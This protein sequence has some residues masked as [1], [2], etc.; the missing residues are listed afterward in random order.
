MLLALMIALQIPAVQTAAVSRVLRGLTGDLNCEIKVGEFALH[1]FNTLIVKDVLILDKNAYSSPSHSPQDTIIKGGTIIARF[2]LKGLL[3]DDG[4]QLSRAEV[5]DALICLV[6]E[7]NEYKS[8]FARAFSSGKKKEGGKNPPTVLVKRARLENVEF[9]MANA[10]KENG[11]DSH[12]GVDWN[13]LDLIL[14]AEAKAIKYSDGTFS[15]KFN[16]IDFSEHCGLE[17]D[18]LSGNLE[19]SETLLSLEEL[20]LKDKY[21]SLKLKELSFSMDDKSGWSN[22]LSEV[23]MTALFEPSTLS[24][25]TLA[26]F[27]PALEGN[28]SEFEI[29]SGKLNG[30]VA[31]L[32]LK[33]LALKETYSGVSCAA[34][35]AVSGLPDLPRLV[36]DC[37]IKELVFNGLGADRLISSFIK[38]KAPDIESIAG[39]EAFHFNAKVR[40]PISHFDVDGRLKSTAGN[41]STGICI[42]NLFTNKDLD[43]HG[44]ASCENLDIG[45][46][47]GKDFV[48]ELSMSTGLNAVAGKEG[49]RLS[50]DSLVVDRLKLL[51]YDYS[52]IRATGIYSGNEFD[53]RVVCNDP[54]LNFMFQ[55][56]ATLSTKTDNAD[57]RF[58]ASLGYADLNAL[59]IDKRGKS[60]ISVGNLI[61]NYT[62]IKR[63][64]LRGSIDLGGLM[65]ENESGTYDIG[66]IHLDSRNSGSRSSI[67]FSSS[68]LDAEYN[69]TKAVASFVKD[70]QDITICRDIPALFG[71]ARD[72]WSGD[73]YEIGIRFHD[74]RDLLAFALPGAYIADSTELFVK[75]N[76]YGDLNGGIRSG[77]IAF[78][79]KYLRNL[80]LKLNNYDHALN[81]SLGSDEISISNQLKL[82]NGD[83]VVYANDNSL[84]LGF[85]YNNLTELENRG[86]FYIIGDLDQS[87]QGN[88][89]ID[90]KTLTSNLYING[91]QWRFSPTGIRYAEKSIGIDR[92]SI[93]KGNQLISIEGGVSPDRSDTLIVN[94]SELDL[95]L[96]SGLINAGLDLQ[97]SINGRLLLTSPTRDNIGLMANITSTG[98]S[99]GGRD[100]GTLRIGSNWDE[101]SGML[102]IALRDDVDGHPVIDAKGGFRPKD[103]NIELSLKLDRLD[104][105]MASPVVKSFLDEMGGYLSGELEASGPIERIDIKSRG[106]RID[107]GLLTIGFTKVPYNLDG[108]LSI[109]NKGI[110]FQDIAIK[111]RHNGSG[112]ISGGIEYDHFKNMRMNTRIR[113][114]NMECINT[115]SNDNSLFYGH[116][117]G[118]GRLGISGPFNALLLDIDATTVKEGRFCFPISSS[119]SVNSNELL[120][121][122]EPMHEIYTDPYELM[123][124]RIQEEK[125]GDSGMAVKVRI[126]A[127]P[128]VEANLSMDGSAQVAMNGNG[129][130]TINLD[131]RPASNIFSITGDYT[132]NRGNCRVSAFGI[133]TKDFSILDGSSIKFNGDIMESE[134]NLNANYQVKTSLAPLLSDDNSV[135]TRRAV[136]CG[137]SITD[138]LKNPKLGFSIDIPDLNPSTKSRV[139]SALSTDDK[140]QKQFVAL[141]VTNNFLPDEQSGVVNNTG[142]LYS[143]VADIMMNQVNSILQKLDIPLD[144]DL[145]YQSNQ[146]G[147]NIFDV[148]LSTQLFNNRVVVNGN[149]GNRQYLASNEESVVGDIDIE[150]KMDKSGQLRLD[151]FSHSA[152][153]YT[154]YLDNSQRNGIGLTYQKEFN[155]WDELLQAMFSGKE[156]RER[157]ESER[158]LKEKNRVRIDIER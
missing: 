97:G 158:L 17:I 72:E 81:A 113:L 124:N 15:G 66:D 62:R 13:N 32:E 36:L 28:G 35:L 18:E 39:K 41:I 44:N 14:N 100:A 75:V 57:Y 49:L 110:H 25:K 95:G 10:T 92:L 16:H 148:A 2:S 67:G 131:I 117:F 31:A 53:G 153:L 136:D 37:D 146:S 51:G 76:G 78:K 30:P 90:A 103:K 48:H 107:N 45:R 54:N 59:N 94:V 40:G 69:G 63:G 93:A 141:L 123:M 77:R 42:R 128:G 156:E 115:G 84:G 129:S 105:A 3:S 125:K 149:I 98:T 121:F 29:S 58:F 83:L 119:G 150:I 144:L 88:P 80:D 19:Y 23:R 27:V 140:I 127:H 145:N 70:I 82:K 9:R 139:E 108:G 157:K 118:S 60:R 134:L 87:S 47:I 132:L 112:I 102:N 34:D 6:N 101:E 46:F 21:S 106:L 154:N 152:D 143:N 65:L 5:H 91:E 22:F 11:S 73:S 79:D 122:K 151:L 104:L 142:M 89:V 1:P 7:D 38:G 116:I 133:A 8:N 99:I 85:N 109:D 26:Y 86:E 138:K 111:D 43:I 114:E 120:S 126:T 61:A 130:G 147:Q 33:G 24:L 52:N 155:T 71:E 20:F 12:Y 64:E 96:V 55:G 4:I 137:L 68:F 74:S 135:A 50:I 56:L